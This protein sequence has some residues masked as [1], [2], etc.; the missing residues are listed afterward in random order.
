MQPK[1]GGAQGARRTGSIQDYLALNPDV[2]ADFQTQVDEGR[3]SSD[4]TLEQ[5]ATN[6]Y[7]NFGLREMAAGTRT[8]F[9]LTSGFT[10][11]TGGVNA[12]LQTR[13]LRDTTMGSRFD[14]TMF[15]EGGLV[16][17]PEGYANG[18]SVPETDFDALQRQLEELDKIDQQSQPPV[19]APS[20]T[21]QEAR[22]ASRGMLDRLNQGLFE[23]VTKPVLG[24]ALDMTVG[25]GDLVQLGAKKGAEALG[26]E[27]KPFVPVSQR[28]QE[29]AGVEGYD[30][31]SPAAIATQ[32]LP[33]ARAKQGATMAATEFGRLFPSLGRETAAFGGSELAAAGAREMFPDS[34]A[35][36]LL[37]SVAG[38]VSGDI[39]GTAAIRRMADDVPPP[40][41]DTE[42]SRLLD[43]IDQATTPTPAKLSRAENSVINEKVGTSRKFRQEAKAEARRIKEKIDPA[44]G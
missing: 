10:G 3:L 30:P 20:D 17:K 5:F 8:P 42:S 22:T 39:G 1:L 40:P 11:A 13:D 26:M 38:G 28:L 24:S 33:F 19:Q 16:K 31:Y 35:A 41:I 27:T 4:M 34:T 44:K 15:A 7:N 25:L 29:S 2:A 12:P 37:A 18:G 43:D 36:E 21:D 9:S 32:I 23:N 6:H 14:G